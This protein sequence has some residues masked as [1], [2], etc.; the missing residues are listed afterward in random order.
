MGTD[1]NPILK[2]KR[3]WLCAGY[4]I[5]VL[6]VY[7]SLAS[8]PLD[9]NLGFPNQDKLYHAAAYFTLMFWF[10]QI[11]HRAR[12]RG[13]LIVAFVSLGLL[14]EFVQSFSPY[15][16]TEVADMAA[17]A[18]GVLLAYFLTRYRLRFMLLRVEAMLL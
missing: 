15:R 5:V 1:E 10:A 18:G 3:L 4:A 6:V 14:M 11:Y 16:Y 9:L 13:A 17:N 12:Q 2:Y 8:H 7:L